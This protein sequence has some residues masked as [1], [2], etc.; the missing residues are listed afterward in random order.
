MRNPAT[1]RT[2]R[3]GMAW[4]VLRELPNHAEPPAPRLVGRFYFR[5]SGAWVRG[6]PRGDCSPVQIALFE[7]RDEARAAI[8]F[9]RIGT[10]ATPRSRDFVRLT[11]VRVYVTVSVRPDERR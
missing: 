10:A 5:G 4:G 1:V 6:R 3:A 7:T 2:A 9:H 8:R 11:P